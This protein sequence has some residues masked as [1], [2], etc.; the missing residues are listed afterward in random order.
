MS[1][2]VFEGRGDGALMFDPELFE[3]GKCVVVSSN[4]FVR[5]LQFERRHL[6]G[7]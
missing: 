6:L 1:E 2:K 5:G 3:F 4:G 7:V